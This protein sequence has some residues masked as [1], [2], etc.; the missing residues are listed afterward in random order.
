MAPARRKNGAQQSAVDAA[1]ERGIEQDEYEK[2]AAEAAKL[3]NGLKPTTREEL[4]RR[5]EH[6]LVGR[7]PSGAVY[8]L[9]QI[10]MERHALAG[11][12]PGSLLSVA[13]EGQEGLR[14]VFEEMA[15]ASKPGAEVDP[16]MVERHGEIREYMDRIVV[17]S[18][19][20]PPITMEDLGDPT[21]IDADSLIPA[22][23]YEWIV[24]VAMRGVRF[25]ADGRAMYGVD[26]LET[27]RIFRFTHEC[28]AGCTGCSRA[29]AALSEVHA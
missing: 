9:R 27:W 2:D 13:L 11:G 16:E 14:K 3:G 21:R 19:V 26:P 28:D 6:K 25:D 20:E 7:A 23:D 24:S 12:L 1:A 29:R 22:P 10:P 5:R 8:R 15:E 4:E 18:V 17:D